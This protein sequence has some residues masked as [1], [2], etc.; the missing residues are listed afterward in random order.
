MIVQEI[1]TALQLRR[2]GR[3]FRGACPVHGGSKGPFALSEGDDGSL[4]VHCHAGCDPRDI[5]SA[6]RRM[7]HLPERSADSHDPAH[8]TV[9]NR[10]RQADTPL[11]WSDRAAH[12]W[13]QGRPI[14][15]TPVEVYLRSRRCAVPAD[16]DLRYL[17]PGNFGP[18]PAMMARITDASTGAALSIHFTRL[19]S[20]GN[21]K[22]LIEKPKIL[23]AGHRKA[24]G[25]VRLGDDAD[26]TAGLGIA[27]GIETSLSVIAMGWRP[28]W[29]ALD[30]GNLG[31][32]PVLNGIEA[33]SIFADADEAGMKAAATAAGRWR[34]AG[35]Q[36]T[37][38]RPALDG[39]D[40]NDEVAA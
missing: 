20:D 38:I 13:R 37:I 16:G 31:A 11:C 22:A 9:P 3:H 32:L 5:L 12:L 7:G 25:V 36:V 26:V 8:E 2:S 14:H 30:A 40:W 18:H 28:C 21:G 15:G 23:L 4:L 1:A 39:T 34:Q 33:L 19:N 6:L 35:R 17:E 27:E 29:A 24:G 10:R